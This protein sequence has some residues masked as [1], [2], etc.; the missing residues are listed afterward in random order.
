MKKKMIIGIAMAM[1]MLSVGAISATAA[2][3]G[4]CCNSGT[5][6]DKQAVQKF[7]QETAAL[8]SALQAKDRELRELNSYEGIDTHK[9]NALEAEI[10]ELKN[11]LKVAA[12][13]YGISTCCLS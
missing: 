6:A 3:T 4:S 13:Q 1:G 10:K 11:S 7:T 5:C 12:G 2:T 8:S 9:A